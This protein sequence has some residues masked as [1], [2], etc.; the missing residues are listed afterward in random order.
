[1]PMVEVVTRARCSPRVLFGLALDVDVHAASLHG[2]G[3]TATTSSG[4]AGLV[5]VTE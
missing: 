3:E 4:P 5:A 1:M 2:S